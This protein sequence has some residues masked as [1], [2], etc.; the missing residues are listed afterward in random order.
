MSQQGGLT[1]VDDYDYSACKSNCQITEPV[2][3]RI[4]TESLTESSAVTIPERLLLS[5]RCQFGTRCFDRRADQQHSGY[6]RLRIRRR[7]VY[8]ESRNQNIDSD[9]YDLF[10]WHR[11]TCHNP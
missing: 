1:D 8:R 10:W 11:T 9:S 3:R 6:E 5:C 4:L 2:R 7:S